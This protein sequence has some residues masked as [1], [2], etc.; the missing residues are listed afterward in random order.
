[1]KRLL[2]A[3]FF[4]L[5]PALAHGATYYVAKTG[6]DGNT[7]IQA[8]SQSAPKLTINAGLRC[9]VSGDTLYIKQGTYAEAINN[10]PAGTVSAHVIVSAFPGDERLA[11]VKPN[12]GG[13]NG[14]AVRFY[15]TSY[16]TVKGFVIDGAN[17]PVQAVRIQELTHHIRIENCELRNAP[18]NCI[19]E[20]NNTVHHNEYIKNYAHDCGAGVKAH[21]IYIRGDDDLVEGNEV[22]NNAG[23][24]I[25]LWA[26]SPSVDNNIVRG[27]N[28]HDNG[29]WGITI[30]AGNNNIAYDNIVQHNKAGGIRVGSGPI[31]NKV[32]NNTISANSGYCVQVNAESL[33]ATVQNNICRQNSNNVV[34]NLGV[35]SFVSHN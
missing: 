1:M 16:V 9:L 22:S 25:H 14:D 20:Q 32:Y 33:N 5:T 19:G 2:L 34:N 28:V 6:N 31:N 23:F 30:G 4:A 12:A 26:A 10:F 24:G 29:Q 7:C 15:N 21:G 17:V 13:V 35:G 11:I 8:T 18:N 27:N 3:L